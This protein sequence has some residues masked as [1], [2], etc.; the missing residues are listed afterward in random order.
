MTR[1]V[2]RTQA[3]R[4]PAKHATAAMSAFPKRLRLGPGTAS[5]SRHGYGSRPKFSGVGFMF[6][7]P[8]G[9]SPELPR[10]DVCGRNPWREARNRQPVRNGFR[11]AAQQASRAA[12]PCCG[13][14]R[15][16][17]RPPPNY[18]MRTSISLR[19]T[20]RNTASWSPRLPAKRRILLSTR[21]GIFR[22]IRFMAVREGL[23][24]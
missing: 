17:D 7:R 3:G 8:P 4:M 2:G 1:F 21:S 6:H 19:F 22:F 14:V 10:S 15:R 16:M 13:T 18:C 24:P 23:P 20:G 9:L 5:G 12:Q 11:T